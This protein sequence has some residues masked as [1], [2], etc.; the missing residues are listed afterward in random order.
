MT[1]RIY[2][3]SSSHKKHQ[4]DILLRNKVTQL[5]Q[6]GCGHIE[7]IQI[8]AFGKKKKLFCRS[9]W[10]KPSVV[11]YYIHSEMLFP[12]FFSAKD[13]SKYHL[14]KLRNSIFSL[15]KV[16]KFKQA[17]PI[18]QKEPDIREDKCVVPNH[19]LNIDDVPNPTR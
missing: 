19:R 17:K 14:V 6:L 18:A 4:D 11:L 2:L 15:Q 10:Y 1:T 7:I 12:F 5:T 16:A 8:I 13:P 3:S 9:V